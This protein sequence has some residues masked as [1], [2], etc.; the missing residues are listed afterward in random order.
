MLIRTR[1]LQWLASPLTFRSSTLLSASSICE[2]C[3]KSLHEKDKDRTFSVPLLPT[4]RHMHTYTLHISH[5]HTHT[6]KNTHEHTHTHTRTHTNI[7]TATHKVFM[8]YPVSRASTN[9]QTQQVYVVG[10]VVNWHCKNTEN[11][12]TSFSSKFY[13]SYNYLITFKVGISGMAISEPWVWINWQLQSLHNFQQ[14]FG[15]NCSFGLK[16]S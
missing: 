12:H 5:T 16:M 10:A 15:S 2:H 11:H 14:K 3:L 4:P 6:R 13:I 9:Q 1:N 8:Q 7:H